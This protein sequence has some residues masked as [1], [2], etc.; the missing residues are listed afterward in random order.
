MMHRTKD[1]IWM[2]VLLVS[3]GVNVCWLRPTASTTVSSKEVVLPV[4]VEQELSEN[5]PKQETEGTKTSKPK[6]LPSERIQLPYDTI[7]RLLNLPTER[8]SADGLVLN[9]HL[10]RA[11][12]VS[13]NERVQLDRETQLFI[14]CLLSSERERALLVA[15][16]DGGSFY[17]LSPDSEGESKTGTYLNKLVAILGKT[18]GRML[19]DILASDPYLLP[20]TELIEIAIEEQDGL[21]TYVESNRDPLPMSSITLSAARYGHLFDTETWRTHIR[22]KVVAEKADVSLPMKTFFDDETLSIFDYEPE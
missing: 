9:N 12:R 4:V 7:K 16:E 8:I 15:G 3:V 17:Q 14:N 18:R 6:T 22:S 5:A 1:I 21:F 20:Q 11:L 10:W 13:A 19:L 2:A